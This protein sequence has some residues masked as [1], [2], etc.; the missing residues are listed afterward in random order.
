MENMDAP[1]TQRVTRQ[2]P[3]DALG[4]SLRHGAA[5]LFLVRHADAIPDADKAAAYEEYDG[6]SLSTRGRAQAE[7]AAAYFADLAIAAIYTSPTDRARET[8]QTIAARSGVPLHID[9]GLREI[10]IGALSGT[11]NLAEHLNS[12]ATIAVR[13]GSWASIPGT[14]SSAAVRGRIVPALDAIAAR[15]PGERLVVVSHAGTINAALGAIAR[16]ESDF[17]FPL[18]NTSISIVR[19]NGGRRVILGANDTA[20]LRA[21]PARGRA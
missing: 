8:A 13:D 21:L 4:L 16:S 19:I 11:G 1:T 7:A 15:H 18:A 17:I 5:E 20:H 2:D 14:E 9:E 12:L 6:H 10:T 3:L